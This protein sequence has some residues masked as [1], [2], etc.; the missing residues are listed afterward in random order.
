VELGPA[1]LAPDLAAL[2][3]AASRITPAPGDPYVVPHFL[4][5]A[6]PGQPVRLPAI[7]GL[8]AGHS[9]ADLHRAVLESYGFA[10]RAG[11][12]SAGYEPA[13]MRF[14]ATGGGARSAFWRQ[15]VSDV[16]G[17]EQSW[18]PAADAAA[19][20][21]ALAAWATCGADIFARG[22][23][24]RDEPAAPTTPDP[25]RRRAEDERYRTWLRLRDAVAGALAPDRASA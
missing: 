19:G 21:A 7:I 22:G 18:R 15:V 11:L 20:S 23:W 12:E 17:V 8:D 4:A 14:I 6:R 24:L 1:P 2:D 25:V 10:A 5:H 9:R 13:R 16:L 3:A